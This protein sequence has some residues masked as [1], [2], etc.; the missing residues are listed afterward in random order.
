MISPEV[1]T[2]R[3]KV[4]VGSHQWLCAPKGAGFLYAL[5]ERQPLLQPL[6]VS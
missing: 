4:C 1:H 6:V 3:E 5:P 2:S